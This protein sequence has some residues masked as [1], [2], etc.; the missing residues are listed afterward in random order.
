MSQILALAKKVISICY[1]K[2]FHETAPYATTCMSESDAAVA[3]E[4]ARSFSRAE[5][6]ISHASVRC[7]VS[8]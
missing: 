8:S 6:M 3:E 1:C 2:F 4:G 7:F 5:Q